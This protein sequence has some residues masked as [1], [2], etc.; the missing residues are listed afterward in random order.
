MA[1]Y[2]SFENIVK[3]LD[4]DWIGL[5]MTP[6][7][8]KE[9]FSGTVRIAGYS[10]FI[11]DDDEYAGWI[12]VIEMP[13]ILKIKPQPNLKEDLI[14]MIRQVSFDKIVLV[15]HY[16]PTKLATGNHSIQLDLLMLA[17]EQLEIRSFRVVEFGMKSPWFTYAVNED[18]YC[19]LPNARENTFDIGFLLP[20]PERIPLCRSDLPGARTFP[21]LGPLGEG[22]GSID[23]KFKQIKIKTNP[24]LVHFIKANK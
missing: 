14:S 11:R 10:H 21:L 12:S 2:P 18:I 20:T 8:M 15:Q 9:Y 24:H 19:N 17:F 23:F 13:F 1:T 6:S 3:L 4:V 5:T 16:L 7:S 22:Y